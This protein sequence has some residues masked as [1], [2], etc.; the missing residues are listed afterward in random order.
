LG[1]VGLMRRPGHTSIM[2]VETGTSSARLWRGGLAG[3]GD[4]FVGRKDAPVDAVAMKVNDVD[5][6]PVTGPAD[7]RAG[8]GAANAK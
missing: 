6:G 3:D 5:A 4:A 2:T 1:E 8:E 7:G